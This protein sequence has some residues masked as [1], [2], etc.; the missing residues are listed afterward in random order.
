MTVRVFQ[1]AALT[2]GLFLV[3]SA[4]ALGLG[5]WLLPPFVGDGIANT[6]S[7][8]TRCLRPSD[9]ISVETADAVIVTNRRRAVREGDPFS[10]FG[11]LKSTGRRYR[12]D[13]RPHDE[14]IDIYRPAGRY[15]ATVAYG[16]ASDDAG[17]DDV[18]VFV[19]MI[20]LRNGDLFRVS[21]Q[22]TAPLGT[23]LSLKVKR[24]G[25]LAYLVVSHA[26]GAGNLTQDLIA[27]EIA[28]CYSS[29]R[30]ATKRKVIDSGQITTF[31]LKGSRLSW[32][33]GK[34]ARSAVLR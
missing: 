33:N 15:V 24:N 30:V 13:Q 11:C 16:F 19:T 28:T 18:T 27:C 26:D 3:V 32:R 10:V 4:M 20:D 9:K 12:V 1:V 5:L 34:S 29:A 17:P 23:I 2:A 6:G 31:A 21:R 8:R 22:A 25:S 7:W 14:E